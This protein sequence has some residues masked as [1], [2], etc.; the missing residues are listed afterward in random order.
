MIGKKLNFFEALEVR[1]DATDKEIQA[2]YKSYQEFLDMPE[3]LNK[4]RQK[5]MLP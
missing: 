5:I 3:Y 4:E 1:R 2:A